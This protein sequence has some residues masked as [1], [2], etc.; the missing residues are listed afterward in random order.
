[1][2]KTIEALS[3]SLESLDTK[4]GRELYLANKSNADLSQM[5][6][7]LETQ[8]TLMY[9]Q[10]SFLSDPLYHRIYQI[11]HFRNSDRGSHVIFKESLNAHLRMLRVKDYTFMP[12]CRI[13]ILYVSI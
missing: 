5:I 2:N 8:G 3:K 13:K 1:M 11:Q 9:A 7:A 10:L 4:L 6:T 12:V